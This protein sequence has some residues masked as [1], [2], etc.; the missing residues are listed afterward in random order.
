MSDNTARLAAINTALA[1]NHA[2][3]DTALAALLERHG[4]VLGAL[5]EAKEALDHYSVR[6]Y[7]SRTD[8]DATIQYRAD[9][10][11]AAIAKVTP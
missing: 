8:I 6:E 7:D 2:D 9:L 4:E 3:L 1:T 5:V 11:L 10:T